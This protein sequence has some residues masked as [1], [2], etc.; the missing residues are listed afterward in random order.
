M[1][2][3]AQYSILGT[4]NIFARIGIDPCLINVLEI[5]LSACVFGVLLLAMFHAAS[6]VFTWYR[7]VSLKISTH[8]YD[9]GYGSESDQVAI[10]TPG[11]SGSVT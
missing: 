6:M 4:D 10:E 9:E 3:Q 11:G 1:E 5:V 2:C 8:S 7:W